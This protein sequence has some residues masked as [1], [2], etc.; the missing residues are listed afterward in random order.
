MLTSG[1]ARYVGLVVFSSYTICHKARNA[2]QLPSS[3]FALRGLCLVLRDAYNDNYKYSYKTPR[4]EHKRPWHLCVV[5]DKLIPGVARNVCTRCPFDFGVYPS[6]LPS[7]CRPCNSARRD[8]WHADSWNGSNGNNPPWNGP[9]NNPPWNGWSSASSSS[10]D[11]RQPQPSWKNDWEHWTG[12]DANSNMPLP[13]PPMLMMSWHLCV[14]DDKLIPG[15]ARNVFTWCPFDFGVYPSLL[16]SVCLPPPRLE[17]KPPPMPPP[18][19]Y[20]QRQSQFVETSM[21]E[22]TDAAVCV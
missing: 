15:V 14:V 7:V 5:D 8:Q 4:P 13:P 11:G 12:H 22:V 19:Y 21:A 1:I 6:L 20:L 18:P 10:G 16:P 2:M 17:P 9:D 3:N